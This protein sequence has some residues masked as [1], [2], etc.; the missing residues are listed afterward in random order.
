MCKKGVTLI[1]CI[2]YLALISIASM[3]FLGGIASYKIKSDNLKKVSEIR[4]IKK[5]FMETSFKCLQE[6]RLE[7]VVISEDKIFIGNTKVFKLKQLKIDTKSM[8]IKIF[9]INN[10]GLITENIKIKFVGE[11]DGFIIESCKKC[12]KMHL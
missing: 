9:Y 2:L 7:E 5:L 4:E 6:D 1:E 11:G 3:I 8:Q 12:K 10:K